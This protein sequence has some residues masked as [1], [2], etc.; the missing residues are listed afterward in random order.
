MTQRILISTGGTG[1]HVVP[2]TILY[3]H[4]KVNFMFL[5]QQIIE[6]LNF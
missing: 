3:E 4:L 5:Y 6:V 1:G 2:A